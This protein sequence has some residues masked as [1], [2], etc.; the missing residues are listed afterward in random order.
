MHLSLD[1][2]FQHLR[3]TLQ[4]IKAT[5]ACDLQIQQKN[6]QLHTFSDSDSTGDP[7]DRKP[8]MGIYILLDSAPI[9]W[10]IKKQSTVARSS[11]EAEYRALALR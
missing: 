10:A 5:V 11:T 4:Y 6:L 2:H 8:T 1:S 3:H 9:S 7:V